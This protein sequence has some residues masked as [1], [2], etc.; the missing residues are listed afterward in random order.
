[1]LTILKEV[2]PRDIGILKKLKAVNVKLMDIKV[3]PLSEVIG[4]KI[5]DLNFQKESLIIAIGRNDYIFFPSELDEIYTN[6]IIFLITSNKYEAFLKNF[7]GS[8]CE[9]IDCI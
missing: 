6:D 1:M 9:Q 2:T 7:F 5:S 8:A 3:N 4:K